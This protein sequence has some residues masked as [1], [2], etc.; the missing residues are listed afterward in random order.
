MYFLLCVEAAF[1]KEE[2]SFTKRVKMP[3]FLGAEAAFAR[4]EVAVTKV[5]A[6]FAK[7]KAAFAKKKAA[8]AKIEAAFLRNSGCVISL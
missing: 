8:V 1:I 5:E 6:A 7:L 3:N 4:V 2:V